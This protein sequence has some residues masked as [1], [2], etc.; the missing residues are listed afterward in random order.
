VARP[1]SSTT[2]SFTLDSNAD[3]TFD[4]G[5]AVFSMPGLSTDA[6]FIGR[7]NPNP[8]ANTLG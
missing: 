6:V 4:S 3:E 2:L 5:D 8:Q 7:W 1:A